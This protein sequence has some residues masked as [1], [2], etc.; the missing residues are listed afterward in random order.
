MP[1]FIQSEKSGRI[2]GFYTLT[3]VN[4]DLS[5]LPENLQKRHPQNYDAGPIA[6]LAV[7]KRYAKKGLGAWLLVDALTKLLTASDVLGFPMII[8]DA[9]EDAISFYEQFGFT[10]FKDTENKL[11]ISVAEVRASFSQ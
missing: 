4:I 5:A 7:D 3:M 10:A 9:K 2:V 1:S 6:R 8:V 11:F